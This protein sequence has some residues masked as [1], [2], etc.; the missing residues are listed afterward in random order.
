MT[1]TAFWNAIAD[2]FMFCFK[3]L[4]GLANSPNVITWVIIIAMLAYWTVQL[5]KHTKAAKRDGT[6]I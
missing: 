5:G 6:Y 3:I 1:W 2:I 4:K